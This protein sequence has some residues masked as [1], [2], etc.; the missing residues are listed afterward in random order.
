MLAGA[1]GIGKDTILEPLRLG[2]GV[3]NFAEASPRD[4]IS[5]WTDYAQAVILRISEMKDQGETDRYKLYEK[6]KVLLAAPPDMLRINVK[7][8]AQY[9]VANVCGVFITTNYVFDGLYLPADDRRHSVAATEVTAGD[10]EEGFFDDFYQYLE[11]GG[12]ADVCAYLAEYDWK[13]AGFNPKKPPEKT[14]AFWQMVNSGLASEVPELQDVL[15]RIG[16]KQTPPAGK[17]APKPC[18]PAVVTVDMVFTEL[19]NSTLLSELELVGTGSG[20][21]VWLR[22]RK[23]RRS[24]PHRFASCGYLPVRNAPRNDGLWIIQGKRQVVYGRRDLTPDERVKA[25]E[26]LDAEEARRAAERVTP[27]K[28]A[29]EAKKR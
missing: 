27:F 7:K 4:I 9:Y 15:D 6:T 18:G 3:S 12:A 20:L 24:I 10:F 21:N 29:E 23:N 16:A 22:D 5:E 19:A 26:Q 8:I 25:A 11:S 17:P 2:V 13:A 28:N 1:P 14:A